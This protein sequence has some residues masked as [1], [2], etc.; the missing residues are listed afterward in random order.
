MKGSSI[1]IRPYTAKQL[2]ALYGVSTNTFYK[3][4]N[5]HKEAVGKKIGHF[6]TIKQVQ[7]IFDR[8]GYPFT[9]NFEEDTT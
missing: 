3:W 5:R 7:I 2:A 9:L 8:L 1:E 4:I 6:Y